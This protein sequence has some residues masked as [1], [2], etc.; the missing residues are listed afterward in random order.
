MGGGGVCA[1]EPAKGGRSQFKMMVNKYKQMA[2]Y[3]NIYLIS[4]VIKEI[5]I[6]RTMGGLPVSKNEK[7]NNIQL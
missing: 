7:S 1:G 6:K 5:Q 3:I 4:V 2:M